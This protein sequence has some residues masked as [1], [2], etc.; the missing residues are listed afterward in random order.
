MLAEPISI[1]A[2]G[3]RFQEHSGYRRMFADGRLTIGLFLPLR[4]YHGDMSVLEAQGDLV[5]SADASGFAAVWVRD[6]PLLDADFGDAGQL[7]DPFTYL[8]YLAARTKRIAL[9]TG[10]VILPLRHP[11]DIA[12]MVASIDRLSGG[13]LVMGVAAGDRPKEFP[14]YGVPHEERADRFRASFTTLRELL[15]DGRVR[16]SSGSGGYDDLE[17]QP[18]AI[19]GVPLLVTGS[20][21]QTGEWIA[22]HSDGWL[23]YPGQ[24]HDAEGPKALAAKIANWRRQMEP[25]VFRPHVTNEWINLVEDRH[26]PRTA[27]QGGRVLR[28][29]TIGLLDLLAEWQKGGV[30]HVALGIQFSVRPPAEVIQQLSEEVM[31]YFASLTGPEAASNRW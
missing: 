19:A 26:H 6:I 11:I 10:S 8:G 24:T 31:P 2:P 9:A 7:F 17:L 23:T 29:G 1:E 16:V 4:A 3:R 12:K 14:A 13:R 25:G 22:D 21:G 5:A 27:L 20:C 15:A 30:N 18:R 28:T